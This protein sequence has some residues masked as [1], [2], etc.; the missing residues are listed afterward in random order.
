MDICRI[1]SVIVC[2]SASGGMSPAKVRNHFCTSAK[3]GTPCEYKLIFV[4]D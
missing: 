2:T 3:L 4:Q 1:E